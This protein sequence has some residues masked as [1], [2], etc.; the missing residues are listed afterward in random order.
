MFANRRAAGKRNRVAGGAVQATLSPG[1]LLGTGSAGGA[2]DAG[3]GCPVSSGEAARWSPARRSVAAW[4]M[5]D[6]ANTTFALGV[7]SRYFGPWLIEEQGGADWQLSAAIVAAM[8]AVIV[9]GPWI[10]AASD[11]RG[12]RVPYLVGATLVCVA[13]T[14]L[15]ATWGIVPSLAFYVVGM[16]GFHT[17]A[18]VYDALLPDVSTPESIGRISGLGVAVGYG[19]SALAIGLG[20]YLL[21]REGY[22]AVFQ[23]LAVAFLLFALPAFVWI[24]ERPR[25]GRT[26]RVPGLLH[27]PGAMI[28]AWRSASRHPGVVRFLVGRFLYTDA[29][30]TMFLFNAVFAKLELGFTDA[31]T[32][33]IALLGILSACF[34]ALSAGRAVDAV[35]PKRV[36]NA[37][38]YLQLAGLASAIAASLTGVSAIGWL[39][40]VFGGAG[41][42]AAWASDRVFMTRLAPAHLIGEFFGLYATVGRFATVA[43]PLAWALAADWLGWGR[44]AAVGVM[45]LFV[46][47]AKIVLQPVEPPARS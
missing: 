32:D 8:L 29:I 33:R 16:I 10:G 27:A 31:Q 35:G 17:G 13:S 9:L 12:R 6:L 37:A 2:T 47:A 7:G 11:R 23:A 34:G 5:Y 25:T 43:G 18:V 44:T 22:A 39:V 36:L 3:E 14:A 19:G 38:L 24:Q 20:M 41:V 28:G 15:L 45:A 1:T 26:E 4:V 30:N 46:V 21:P 40:A 42:G